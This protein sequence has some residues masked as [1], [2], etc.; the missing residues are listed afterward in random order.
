LSVT[1]T[2]QF[3]NQ[4]SQ[5]LTTIDKYNDILRDKKYTSKDLDIIT[6]RVAEID[7]YLVENEKFIRDE[8]IRDEI[9]IE[10]R[11]LKNRLKGAQT[12]NPQ[13]SRAKY[14]DALRKIADERN[15]KVSKDLVKNAQ[16]GG[17]VKDKRTIIGRSFSKLYKDTAKIHL[18]LLAGKYNEKYLKDARTYVN[19]YKEMMNTQ[20]D[21]NHVLSPEFKKAL[22][23]LEKILAEI[24]NGTYHNPLQK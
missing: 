6:Q 2:F 23:P 13:D 21:K 5:L 15:N 9:R 18:N 11:Y 14:L 24:E 12:S 10:F 1:G 20:E 22:D 7:K 8:Y 4:N 3:S 17:I 16:S 19:Y